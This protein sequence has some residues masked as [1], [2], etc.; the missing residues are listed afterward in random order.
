MKK[1]KVIDIEC[2]KILIELEFNKIK[3]ILRLLDY[4]P[5]RY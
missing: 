2:D 1:I 4:F 3:P 5:K